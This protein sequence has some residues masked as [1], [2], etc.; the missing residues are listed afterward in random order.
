V[1][2]ENG[3]PNRGAVLLTELKALVDSFP[4]HQRGNVIK[5]LEITFRELN[6]NHESRHSVGL[7]PAART[8]GVSPAKTTASPGLS[9]GFQTKIKGRDKE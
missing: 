7:Q 3:T 1:K 4:H 2:I 6:A 8:D 9:D 5:M